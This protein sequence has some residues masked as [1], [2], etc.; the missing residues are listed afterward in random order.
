VNLAG[1]ALA[2]LGGNTHYDDDDDDD[3]DDDEG[4]NEYTNELED[5]VDKFLAHCIVFPYACKAVLRGNLLN[6]ASEEGPRFLQCGMLTD[7]DLGVV[8]RHGRP[9]FVCLEIL[10]RIMYEFFRKRQRNDRC[11]EVIA[12]KNNFSIV[13]SI[14]WGLPPSMHNGALLAMEEQLNELNLNF[15][16]CLKINNTKMPSSYTLFMRSFI[17]F[18]FLLTSLSWAPSM[19]WSTPIITGVMVFLLDTVIVIGDQMM[20]PFDLQWAGLPLKKFCVII[21][22][23]IMNVSRRHADID[24]MLRRNSPV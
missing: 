9:P 24:S 21:E 4:A 18:Y 7:A 16:A 23:E 14:E 17:I 11:L 1:Q 10:R 22:H 19:K 15:G 8:I 3:D 13:N 2:W 20:R 5:L 6:D 12:S